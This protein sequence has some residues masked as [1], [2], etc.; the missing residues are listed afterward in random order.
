MVVHHTLFCKN[1]FFRILP[2]E[3]RSELFKKVTLKDWPA[4]KILFQE[5]DDA[6]LLHVIETG[7]VKVL[8]SA[9]DE[10]LLL[11]RIFGPGESVGELPVV[12][13][14]PYPA[15]AMT[16]E[17]SRIWLIP[18]K[19]LDGL[20][21]TVPVFAERSL[22]TLSKNARVLQERL[23]ELSLKSIEGR[24]VSF[25]LRISAYGTKEQDGSVWIPFRL[26]RA[27]FAAAVN[28]RVE[29]L[30]RLIRRWEIEGLIESKKTG[31]RIKDLELLKNR[32][33]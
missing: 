20:R 9:G 28:I 22:A 2:E 16:V 27:D 11:L 31:I 32:P 33:T 24:L 1:E 18:R 4:G 23:T 15:T 3:V 30:I 17:K 8:K 10:S 6:H 14:S 25:L 29:T 5:G 21:R 26:S 19:E 13:T 7:Y 12:S